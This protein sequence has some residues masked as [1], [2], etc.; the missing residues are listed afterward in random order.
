[1]NP[2]IPLAVF[3]LLTMVLGFLFRVPMAFSMG[4]AALAIFFLNDLPLSGFAPGAFAAVNSFPLLAVPFFVFAGTLMHYSGI[5]KSL[6]DLIES[7]LHRVHGRL[8]YVVIV[9]SLGFGAI[10]G[11]A[12]ALITTIGKMITP[13]MV[14]TGYGLNYSTAILASCCFL[15]VL[16]PPSIPG[17]LYAM[18]SNTSVADVWL[19]TIAPAFMISALYAVVNHFKT[20]K[21]QLAPVV[22][23]DAGSQIGLSKGMLIEA[24]PA[25]L[26]PVII[27]GGIYGGVFTPTEAGAVAAIYGFSYFLF[28]RL[29]LRRR[30]DG[31]LWGITIEAAVLTASVGIIIV[32][33]SVVG[34]AIALSG[35]SDALVEVVTT[36]VDS[37]VLF[38]MA[39]NVLFLV[40]GAFIDENTCILV[41]VPLLM[42][43]VS[44]YG[45]DP[46]HF[47]AV[48]LV[49]TCIG[50][51]LPPVASAIFIGS[52]LTG[53]SF[54][55]IVEHIWPFVACAL[56]VLLIITYV[57]DIV[58][59]L[60]RNF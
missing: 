34:R 9:G 40:L 30:L 24:V 52:K 6:L 16:I 15:G 19:A 57:P 41:I 26:M 37:P 36:N 35:V 43:T 38:L 14:A 3:I 1:M 25:L 56:V 50:F 47:G 13:R 4:I 33:A 45:I 12:M 8:G 42:P 58:L 44:A 20:R 60:P 28:K 54:Q 10:T 48:I 27:F 59:W 29:V 22:S 53:A 51:I 46:V 23:T 21:M 18:A 17:I 11:S 49:N 5:S 2:L 32:F 7:L 31:T 39:V 55:G